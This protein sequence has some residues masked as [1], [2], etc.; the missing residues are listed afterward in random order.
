MKAQIDMETYLTSSEV[1][2][3]LG[4]APSSIKRWTQAGLL[5]CVTTPGRHRRF[6]REQVDDF[7][8]LHRELRRNT[9]LHDGA[10]WIQLLLDAESSMEV[11]AELLSERVRQGSW[12]AVADHLGGV[13][14]DLGERWQRG[15]ISVLDEHRASER[16]ARALAACAES[17]P[18]SKQAPQAFL[19]VANGD[20][21]TLG[22]NL[23]EL[24]L[25][26]AGWGVVWGG[27]SLPLD[28]ILARLQDGGL[29]LVGLSASIRSNES[30]HLRSIVQR[31]AAA[32]QASGA[33]LVLGGSGAWPEFPE[34]AGRVHRMKDFTSLHEFLLSSSD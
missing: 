18:I 14:R 17:I 5:K 31:L 32:C 1:A 21:H 12:H 19:A 34:Y 20:E 11:H 29:G 9:P 33:Y 6:T 24:C 25:R 15:E 30:Q 27:R 26:E 7:A 16:L 2:R 8:R 3:L 10:D 13:L 23:A 22:L 4:V 28:E